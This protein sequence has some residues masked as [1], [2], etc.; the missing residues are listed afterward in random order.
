VLLGFGVELAV[1]AALPP[2]LTVD[3]QVVPLAYGADPIDGIEPNVFGLGVSQ[4]HCSG[5]ATAYTLA[6]RGTSFT[7]SCA[8]TSG[9]Q[10]RPVMIGLHARRSYTVTLRAVQKRA[11]RSA[12]VGDAHTLSVQVPAANSK[13]WGSTG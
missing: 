7:M 13:S 11:G 1:A 12:R 5:G 3:V 8:N 9:V 2:G 10:P 6:V 4:A